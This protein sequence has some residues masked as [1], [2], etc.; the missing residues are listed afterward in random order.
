MRK[1]DWSPNLQKKRRLRRFK[2]FELAWK[3]VKA[4]YG[5]IKGRPILVS[6]LTGY[7]DDH[8][9]DF[10]L[11]PPALVM[12]AHTSDGDLSH[13]VDQWLD[14]YWNL[15]LLEPHP[16]L[17]GVESLWMFGTS[18]NLETGEAQHA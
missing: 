15:T 16:Q 1:Q 4:D 2:G 14:P 9:I 8:S 12:V 5:R 13:Q 3:D 10:G 11:E 18:Y 17:K 6:E 7:R